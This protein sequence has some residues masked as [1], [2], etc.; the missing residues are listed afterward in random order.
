MGGWVGG[1]CRP[2]EPQGVPTS[3]R[4]LPCPTPPPFSH[5]PVNTASWLY[6]RPHCCASAAR[7]A[8]E[9][10]PG[11]AGWMGPPLLGLLGWFQAG[12]FPTAPSPSQGLGWPLAGRLPCVLTPGCKSRRLPGGSSN[13]RA[14]AAGV[15]CGAPGPGLTLGARTSRQSSLWLPPRAAHHRGPHSDRPP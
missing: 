13:V 6:L 5:G 11:S 2:L 10:G 4:H 15:A 8:G 12:P 1:G 7:Q 14:L 3:G 9:P